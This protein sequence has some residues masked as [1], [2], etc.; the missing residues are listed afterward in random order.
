[1]SIAASSSDNSTAISSNSNRGVDEFRDIGEVARQPAVRLDRRV[2]KVLGRP[3]T[4]QDRRRW[5]AARTASVASNKVSLIGFRAKLLVRMTSAPQTFGT[6]RTSTSAS[7][8][9]W[10]PGLV[11]CRGCGAP[12]ER[13][14]SEHEEVKA[15]MHVVGGEP[16]FPLRLRLDVMTIGVGVNP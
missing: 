13:D 10:S 8:S 3:L 1:M 11:S 15:V 7:R 2:A 12:V 16:V 5:P 9:T 6:A 14:L 4:L